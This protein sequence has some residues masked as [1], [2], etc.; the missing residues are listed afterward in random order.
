MWR[1]V[2]LNVTYHV[3]RSHGV[4]ATCVAVKCPTTSALSCRR[5]ADAACGAPCAWPSRATSGAAMAYV[6]TCPAVMCLITSALSCGRVAGAACGVPCA[7][8]TYTCHVWRSNGVYGDV[9][10]NHVSHDVGVAVRARC[11][12]CVWLT[13]RRHITCHVRCSYGVLATCIAVT[14]LTTLGLSCRCAAGAAC[15]RPC[16]GTSLAMSGAAT[17]CVGA[18]CT[19]VTCITTLALPCGH[20]ADGARGAPCACTSRAKQGAAAACVATCAIAACLTTLELSFKCVADAACGAPSAWPS[21]ATLG[22][23]TSCVATCAAVTCLTSSVFV[24][25]AR[26]GC[27]VWCALRQHVTCHIGRSHIMR[28]SL[29]CSRL[30]HSV[31]PPRV[32]VANAACWATCACTSGATS[33]AATA[34]VPDNI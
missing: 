9:H 31:V 34:C 27:S 30:P 2:C 23:A 29:R 16:E 19:S 24:V 21:H 14:C 11:R 26:C 7:E 18:T 10:R 25:R 12:H 15:D 32:C 1:T 28:G 13:L 33:I 5:V 20:V 17:A 6:G 8:Q 4:L 3:R 22:V